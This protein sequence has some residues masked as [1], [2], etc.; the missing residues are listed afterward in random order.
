MLAAIERALDLRDTHR[1]RGQRLDWLILPELAVH[2]ADVGTH[3]VPF[4]RARRAIVLAGLTYQQIGTD[5]RLVNSALWIV[6]T[7]SPA[8]GL[9]I[10]VRRQ[11]K[12][13]LAPGEHELN[14]SFGN[15]LREFRPCQ[16]L[17]GYEWD[18]HQR[19]LWLT[20]SVCYDATDLALAA[21]LRN[22]T[23]VF[24]IPALNRDVTTFDQMALALHYHMFQMVI[25]ANNGSYGGSNAYWPRYDPWIR[26]VFHVHG[27]PQAS[28]SFLEIDDIADFVARGITVAPT[29]APPAESGISRWK[30]PP[31]GI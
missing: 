7:W 25:V 5:P 19:P 6:P 24:A 22:R 10:R 29:I 30:P 2:P 15:P 26:Q 16:W 18:P 27:Q 23:D 8:Y 12:G 4:A 13:N 9:Q 14:A 11:G 3:L 21:D 28:I 1:D 17:L 20:A 31:V